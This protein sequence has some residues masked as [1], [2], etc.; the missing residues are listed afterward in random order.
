M[1]SA[2]RFSPAG[3]LPLAC[4]WAEPVRYPD[5]HARRKLVFPRDHGAHPEYRIEW[6]YVTGW[7]DGAT[8]RLPD[9]LLPRAARTRTATTRA[10]S[11][12]GRSCS[13]TPRS[14]IRSAAGCCTTSARRAPASRSPHAETD[15]HRR[16]GRRLAPRAR[17]QPLPGAIAA[18][19]FELDFTL[20]ANQLVAAGRAG[21][22]RKGQRPRRG[23]LLLQPAAPQGARQAE[24]QGRAS[25][26]AW[27]DHEWSSAYMAP[28]ASGWD[29]CGI[30]SRTAAR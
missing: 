17:R 22:S 19:D 30:N 8:A 23:E 26:E 7:L 18:R 12:R 29:W 20:L 10:S 11:P 15:A 5:G 6:W 13:R 9:H 27:L 14:P 2:G 4:R 3:L 16:L 21:F 25:G 28:E 1:R 24:R